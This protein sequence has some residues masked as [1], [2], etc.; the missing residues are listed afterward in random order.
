MIL[1]VE[2]LIWRGRALSR[3]PSGKV[4]IIEPGVFPGEIIEIEPLKEKRDYLEASW[5]RILKPIHSRKHHPCNLSPWCGGCRFGCIPQKEQL[6]FKEEMVKKEIKRAVREKV[7]P[8]ILEGIQ[9]YPSYPAWR[10]R[11]RGQ[12]HVFEGK[13][14]FKKMQTR[15]LVF[16]PD[17]LLFNS[18]LSSAMHQ[19]C[20]HLPEG[21]QVM[22]IE[23]KGSKVFT[24]FDSEYLK[25]S[26]QDLSLF[27]PPGAFFQANWQLNQSLINFI[28]SQADDLEQIADLYAGSGNFSLPLARQGKKVL[29]VEGQGQAAQAAAYSKEQAGLSYPKIEIQDLN[30]IPAK[31]VIQ[32]WSPEMVILD[33][34]RSGGSKRLASLTE[35][36]SLKRLVWISCDVVNTCRDLKP[37][38]SAG[39][40]IKNI[41]LFDM[42]PQTWHIEVVFVLEKG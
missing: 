19:V 34:P 33:P 22:A 29:A 8:L 37:F 32:K 26:F 6:D 4:V 27:I 7:D 39:W 24:E 23:P 9:I 21:R 11:Y 5:N 41:T 20:K 36:S 14:Y 31:Q 13:P 17:C 12:V 2:Q 15:E 3:L 40:T 18:S 16:C 38:L 1:E 10:Y 28:C 35:L 25:F 42:F 30:K